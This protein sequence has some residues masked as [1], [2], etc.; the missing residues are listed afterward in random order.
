MKLYYETSDSLKHHGIKG[1]KWGVRRYQ[2]KDGTL[3]A[4]G[5]KR[6]KISRFDFAKIKARSKE[7]LK[8][9]RDTNNI[10]IK[11]PSGKHVM[12]DGAYSQK[13]GGFLHPS[14]HIVNDKGEVV[15][16]Y[17]NGIYGDNCVARSKKYVENNLNLKDYFKRPM[18]VDYIF[19]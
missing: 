16:S 18:E 17:I 8:L 15:L 13:R 4:K 10:N 11:A 5:K 3:T 12:V 9:I 19:E 7:Q 6:N 2:N 14:K 1:Q